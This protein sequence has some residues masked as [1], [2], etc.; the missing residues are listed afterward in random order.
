MRI[1]LLLSVAL[2]LPAYL[3]GQF[4][5]R[6]LPDT[7]V[8][9]HKSSTPRILNVWEDLPDSLECVWT[10]QDLSRG[11]S[12]SHARLFTEKMESGYFRFK[13]QVLDSAEVVQEDSLVLH[14]APPP[15]IVPTSISIPTCDNSGDGAIRLKEI[16][17]AGYSYQWN[18]GQTN[19]SI[20]GLN[21]GTYEVLLSDKNN[22]SSKQTFAL[23]SPEPIF[24][25]LVHKEDAS[26][27]L[28]NGAAVVRASGGVGEFRYRWDTQNEYEGVGLDGLGPG[29]Y[30]IRAEDS[31]GCWD[32]LHINIKDLPFRN[33]QI[34]S[35]PSDTIALCVS[36]ASF[37][38]EAADS[39]AESYIWDFGDGT[40]PV[41]TKNP[42]HTF[43]EA[44]TYTVLC[45]M[46]EEGNDCPAKDSLQIEVQH[47]G[48][49]VVPE[50][51]SPNGD[52]VNDLFFVRGY[53][54]SIDMKIYQKNGKLI[55]HIDQPDEKWNGR[56]EEGR[57]LSQG[58][59]RYELNAQLSVCKDL[60]QTGVIKLVR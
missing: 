12:Y 34:S 14:I 29:L 4:T 6:S 38:F 19:A 40:E 44:G 45:T 17:G 26:C 52:G 1:P 15:A 25:D 57:K 33:A 39:Y 60:Q 7:L 50:L 3:L 42:S 27:K 21:S 43:E 5:D 11:P 24:I 53:L 35:T 46:Y 48:M 51:F 2:L 13:R 55:K 54:Q 59:Y 41:N 9:C 28:E 20:E 49:I 32:T 47:D 22:C 36:E 30:T 56:T 16:A 10:S 18:S 37:S 23:M 31:R 8:V 58:E